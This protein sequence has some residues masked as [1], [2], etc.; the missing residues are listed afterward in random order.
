[1]N[2]PNPNSDQGDLLALDV[3]HKRIG[4]AR[5]GRIAKLPQPLDTLEVNGAEIEA[6][7]RLVEEYGVDTIVVGWP[8]KQDD[9]ETAQTRLVGDF[10][11]KLSE[12]DCTI[13]KQDEAFTSVDAEAELAESKRA[14]SKADID[15]RA[16]LIILEN[17][18]KDNP[19]E[20]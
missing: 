14:F 7:K 17:Y 3:G 12:I 5:A 2:S 16:A 20:I 1:M 15:A 18:I 13:V 19:G 11:Q 9:S 10:I 8:R 4:V 6:I